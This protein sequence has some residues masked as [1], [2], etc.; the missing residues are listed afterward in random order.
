MNE[1]SGIP[2]SAQNQYASSFSINCHSAV[3]GR[4]NKEYCKFE[5][6]VAHVQGAH[7]YLKLKL[8]Y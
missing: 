8:K 3:R 7:H 2:L 1:K 6:N 5:E 4:L